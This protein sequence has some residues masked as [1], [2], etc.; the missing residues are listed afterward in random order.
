MRVGPRFADGAEPCPF[1]SVDSPRP[2]RAVVNDGE[3][4]ME[5]K[6]NEIHLDTD[7]ARAGS[8]ENVTRWVLR[9]GTA[10]VVIAFIIVAWVILYR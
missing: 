10:G 7:E 6:G 1:S 4:P 9:F 8:E 5:R 3:P 2:R